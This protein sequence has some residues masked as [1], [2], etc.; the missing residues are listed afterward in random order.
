MEV[1]CSGHSVMS[2]SCNPMDGVHQASLSM[3]FLRHEYWSRLPFPS[4]GD[5]HYPRI[6]PMSPA[7]QADSLLTEP[8]GQPSPG[9]P[10]LSTPCPQGLIPSCFQVGGALPPPAPPRGPSPPSPRPIAPSLLSLCVSLPP[11]V[12]K[13]QSTVHGI[14]DLRPRIPVDLPLPHPPQCLSLERNVS[15]LCQSQSCFLVDAR[16]F[17]LLGKLSFL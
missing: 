7:L 3:G 4:P 9:C 15:V 11:L 1:L 2:D 5:L 17:W 13:L 10:N 16:S 8:P 6:E 14:E 12:L